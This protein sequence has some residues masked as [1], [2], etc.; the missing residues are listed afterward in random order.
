MGK[1]LAGALVVLVLA[2]IIFFVWSNVKDSRVEQLEAQITQMN[3]M[4]SQL[5]D[6]NT[7][8]KSQLAKVQ[9]EEESL[10]AQNEELRKAVAS[11]KATGKLPPNINAELHP[12]K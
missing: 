6:E 5:G 10:A 11:V 2:A 12:P 1:F 4:I 8:L 3:N 9:S 7:R